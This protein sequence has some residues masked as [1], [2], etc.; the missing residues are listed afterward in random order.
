MNKNTVKKGVLRYLFLVLIIF[1]VYYLFSVLNQKVN[2]LT[3]QELTTVLEQGNV[4]EM[5]ITPKERAVVYEIRGKLKDYKENESFFIRVPLTDSIIKN[6][7]EAGGNN[8]F[9]L[10][11]NADPESSSFWLILINVLPMVLIIGF[12]FFF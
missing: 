5:T 7:L 12:G 6:V 4:T 9:K 3:Y 8:E 10:T 1:G 2:V 11:T